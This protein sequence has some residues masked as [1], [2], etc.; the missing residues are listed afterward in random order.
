MIAASFAEVISIGA[1]VPFLAVLTDPQRVFFHP[2]AD[3]IIRILNLTDP[4]ELVFPIVIAFGCAALVAGSIR[5]LLLK[6]GTKLAFSIGADLS[7]SMYRRT[8]YQPYSVHVARNSSGII[9]GI[10]NKSTIVI[11]GIVMPLITLI[12]SVM[13]FSAVVGTLMIVDPIIA[14]VCIGSF[15]FIYSLIMIRSKNRLRFAGQEIAEH[16][17]QVIKSMQ[18]GLGGIRDILIDGSQE[19]YVKVYR[20]ADLALRRSQRANQVLREAPRYLVESLGTIFIALTA[21][22]IFSTAD[23]FSNSVA[24]LGI[25]ALGCQRMLPVIQQGYSA[26]GSLKTSHASLQDVIELLDQPL[27]DHLNVPQD[28]GMIFKE[29]ISL[30][31]VSFRYA[32]DLPWVL[33]GLNIHINKGS[34]VGILGE[35]GSGKSSVLDILMGLLPPT[36]GVME[37]DGVDVNNSNVLAWQKN[38]GHVPQNIFLSDATILENIAFGVPFN[39]I[40]HERAEMA[41]ERAQIASTIDA[42][43]MKYNACVGERGVKLSGGQRQRLGIARALYKQADFII[44]DEATSALDNQT[45]AAVISAIEGLGSDLTIIMVAH[46]LSTL[47]GCDQ[48]FELKNGKMNIFRMLDT[49]GK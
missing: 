46:R 32:P 26:W 16:S 42:L 7:V 19:A 6:Y 36:K 27:P 2:S 12:S 23:D 15:G 4:S 21:Y 37:V 41:A 30:R 18:E 13:I 43:D 20:D 31:N 8:L 29:N 5:W 40:D 34:R 25:L 44:F 9:N 47:K 10:T 17:T 45:E 22:F 1:V 49:D 35:T 33:Q 28:N 11:F 39:M 24:I 3:P 14:L 38:I 48:V